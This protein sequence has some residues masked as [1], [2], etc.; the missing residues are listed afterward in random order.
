MW[1]NWLSSAA[2]LAAGWPI[3][4]SAWQN[5]RINRN[6]DI[7]FLM[8]I[9]AIGA[10]IIGAYTEAGMVMVL[11]ALGEALEGFTSEKAHASIEDL[12]D[13]VP[14]TATRLID[15]NGICP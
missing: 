8:S 9:A 10:F 12:L 7:N 6:I 5:L 14:Q 15:N 13:I 1:I 11:F 4:R 2:I 3:A